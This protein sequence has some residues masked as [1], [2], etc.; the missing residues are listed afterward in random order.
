[1]SDG[2]AITLDSAANGTIAQQ[3]NAAIVKQ[4]GG[5]IVYN[6]QGTAGARQGADGGV[7]MNTMRTP[8]G[9][10]YQL[11]L[12]DGTLV[13]LNAASSITYPIAFT[14][15]QRSVKISGEVY[16]E[17]T[18]NKEQPFVVDVDGR[19]TVE[20][21]GTGFDVNAY[22]DEGSVKTTLLEGS[23][24]VGT[25]LLRPG[26]QAQLGQK[27]TSVVHN[28]NLDKVMAWKNGLF[29]F[30]DVDLKEVMRQLARWYDIE[31]IYEKGVPNIR[32]EGEIS[33]NINLSNLLKVLA[34]AEV[35][36]RIEEG[37]RLVVLP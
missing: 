32:F 36:F 10:R 20:V 35:K 13:W 25:V 27:G 8:R 12:P 19:T 4:A 34:R 5:Q 15:R 1:L 7:M 18:K 28:V 23:V 11:A 26:E 33:R 6:L 16:F 3:G 2:T 14:G 24:K 31:V 30:E 37:R 29:N 22:T 17:V 9:G 21:L